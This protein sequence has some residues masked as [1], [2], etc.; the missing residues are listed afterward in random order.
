MIIIIPNEH[1]E[2]LG[3]DEN[4]KLIIESNKETNTITKKHIF[5]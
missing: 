5:N 4:T 1:F 3:W 2:N